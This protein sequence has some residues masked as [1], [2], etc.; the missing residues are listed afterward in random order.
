MEHQFEKVPATRARAQ[1]IPNW[2]R[3]RNPLLH[4]V[5]A[6]FGV[7][8]TTLVLGPRKMTFWHPR[9]C[10]L[11]MAICLFTF[12]KMDP[13]LFWSHL[14]CAVRF[15]SEAQNGSF[16]KLCFQPRKTTVFQIW[17]PLWSPPGSRKHK[18]HWVFL[19]TLH[20]PRKRQ[21]QIW[22]PF[23]PPHGLLVLTGKHRRGGPNFRFRFVLYKNLIGTGNLVPP[24]APKPLK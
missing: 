2:G 13:G 10:L 5:V 7:R 9:N 8:K 21:K 18:H 20:M 19:M 23:G 6:L 17:S 12:A 14:S 16:T 4:F 22:S 15:A 11:F 3:G 24:V 1:W